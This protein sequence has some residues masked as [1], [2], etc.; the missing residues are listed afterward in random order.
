LGDE[1][2]LTPEEL[3]AARGQPAPVGDND[4]NGENDATPK[5]LAKRLDG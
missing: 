4:G 2:K 1:S 3:A 5:G